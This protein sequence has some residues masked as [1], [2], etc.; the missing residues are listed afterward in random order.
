MI[1]FYG[2]NKCST[3]RKA[4]KALTAAGLQYEFRDITLHPPAAAELKKYI[5]Q[6]GDGPRPFFNTSG[7]LYREL[8]IKT[9]REQIPEASQLDLLCLDG[10]L[11]KRPIISDGK[12]TTVGWKDDTIKV[13]THV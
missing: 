12:T 2:Y 5:Q 6:L 1:R 4:E 11:L 8:D 10:R 3:C 9:K 7:V 13:W